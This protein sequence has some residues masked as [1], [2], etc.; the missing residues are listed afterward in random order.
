MGG[1]VQLP[2]SERLEN[3]LQRPLDVA[4][5]MTHIGQTSVHSF[6]S[7]SQGVLGPTKVSLA[8]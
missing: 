6:A 3:V 5:A 8:M 7:M 1:R 2:T 4:L